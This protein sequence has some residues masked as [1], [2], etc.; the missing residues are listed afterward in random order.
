[1]TTT[2]LAVLLALALGTVIPMAIEVVTKAN[3]SPRVRTFLNGLLAAV[4]GAASS[5]HSHVPNSSAQWEQVGV[6]VLLAWIACGVT[7]VAGAP[8]EELRR[9]IAR[10]TA[11]FGV[12]PLPNAS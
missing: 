9:V 1:M 12:G 5:V 8:Q 6:T 10:K 11:N 7:F 3:V 2:T 4:A